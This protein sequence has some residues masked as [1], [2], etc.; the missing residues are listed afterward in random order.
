MSEPQIWLP[1][2]CWSF[3]N[4]GGHLWCCFFSRRTKRP[5]RTDETEIVQEKW[6]RKH[7][8]MFHKT[9]RWRRRLQTPGRTLGERRAMAGRF[10]WLSAL[11]E[12]YGFHVAPFFVKSAEA[13]GFFLLVRNRQNSRQIVLVWARVFPMLRKGSKSGIYRLPI[14]LLRWNL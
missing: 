8:L 6:I 2:K 3:V 1:K 4:V 12:R 13:Y 5:G 11:V 14:C 7:I 10:T 9:E